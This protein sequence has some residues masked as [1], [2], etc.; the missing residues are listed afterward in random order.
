M[1]IKGYTLIEIMI[2]LAVFAILAVITSTSMYH[3]FTTRSRVNEQA[4][5]LNSLQ[6]TM[7]IIERDTKQIIDRAIRGNDMLL[8]PSFIGEPGYTEFT[9][10]GMVNPNSTEKRSTLKRVAYLCQ[11]D[12]LIRRSWRMLDTPSREQYSDKVLLNKIKRCKF[13]YLNRSRQVLSEWRA[14]AVQQNQT[15]EP[16]PVAF[17]MDIELEVWGRMNL[18]FIVPEALYG[19]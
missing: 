15:K 2:A 14:N 12:K 8:I 7:T 1:K 10:D 6:L 18:L 16:L 5:R 4:D 9:R 3:A 11:N 19:S 13:S 17:Q